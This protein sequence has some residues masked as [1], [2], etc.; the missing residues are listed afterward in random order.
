MSEM[1]QTPAEQTKNPWGEGVTE[2]HFWFEGET[3]HYFKVFSEEYL[4]NK[5]AQQQRRNL[6]PSDLERGKAALRKLRN[7]FR[8]GL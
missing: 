6:L 1:Q 7:L 2:V 5:R 4:Q 3:V 8:R